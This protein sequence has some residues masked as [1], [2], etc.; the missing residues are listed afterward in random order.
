MLCYFIGKQRDEQYRRINWNL[1]LC[2]QDPV[3]FSGTL[4]VNLDPFNMYSD[5]TIWRALEL[6]HL[7]AYAKGLAA[8]LQHEIAEGGENLRYDFY[9]SLRPIA[10]DILI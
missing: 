1:I 8:G 3:L 9:C 10:T 5:E 6:A 2:T 4:R 7:K